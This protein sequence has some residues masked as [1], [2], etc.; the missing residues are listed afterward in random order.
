M[1]QRT[2]EETFDFLMNQVTI[3][4]LE[5][6]VSCVEYND[7]NLKERGWYGYKEIFYKVYNAR[8]ARGEKAKKYKPHYAIL[9][10]G[11]DDVQVEVVKCG[12]KGQ[13]IRLE[14]RL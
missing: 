7:K 6:Q 10:E 12:G 4:Y 2:Q 9:R 14:H 5:D 11:F 13:T 1:P 3:E 8:K